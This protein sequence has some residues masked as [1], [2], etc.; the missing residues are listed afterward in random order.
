MFLPEVNI[1]LTI[2][3]KAK[4]VH[5]IDFANARNVLPNVNDTIYYCGA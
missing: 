1:I 3:D 2:E 5:D 4:R